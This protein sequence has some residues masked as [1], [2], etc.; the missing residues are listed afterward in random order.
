MFEKYVNFLIILVTGYLYSKIYGKY[1]SRNLRNF[2][3][4]LILDYEHRLG[5]FRNKS[6]VEIKNF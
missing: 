5:S 6:G 4:I 2:K 3:K 1:Q